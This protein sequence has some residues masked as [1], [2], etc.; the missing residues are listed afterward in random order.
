MAVFLSRNGPLSICIYWLAV[1]LSS[2]ACRWPLSRWLTAAS[3]E[4]DC[5]NLVAWTYSATFLSLDGSRA[6]PLAE[7]QSLRCQLSSVLSPRGQ[8]ETAGGGGDGKWLQWRP[9]GSHF[10][11]EPIDK[12][13]QSLFV[14]SQLRQKTQFHHFIVCSKVSFVDKT[15]QQPS[16]RSEI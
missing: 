3:E 13:D 16:W 11:L 7:A 15:P 14:W 9:V 2:T 4:I 10:P 1:A 5:C 8:Q 12:E 6:V